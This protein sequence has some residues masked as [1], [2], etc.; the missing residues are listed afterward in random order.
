MRDL[1]HK[2]GPTLQPFFIGNKLERG[3]ELTSQNL[4]DQAAR[5]E[6]EM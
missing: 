4:R 3:L 1:S 6:M 5:L 2:I